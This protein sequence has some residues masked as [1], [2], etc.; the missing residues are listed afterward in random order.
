MWQLYKMLKCLLSATQTGQLGCVFRCV[1]SAVV[2]AHSCRS[3]TGIVTLTMVAWS[4]RAL[5]CWAGINGKEVASLRAP[6]M[7]FIKGQFEEFMRD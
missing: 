4:F 5:S 7:G 6:K 2:H 1:L 3:M